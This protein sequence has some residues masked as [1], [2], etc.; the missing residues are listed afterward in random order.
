M[1]SS[2]RPIRNKL[3]SCPDLTPSE[4]THLLRER[5]LPRFH[6]QAG[7]WRLASRPEQLAAL[8]PVRKL[9]RSAFRPIT[10]LSSRGYCNEDIAAVLGLPT[11]EEFLD[12]ERCRAI[13]EFAREGC[14]FVWATC[15]EDKVWLDSCLQSLDK[16][17]RCSGELSITGLSYQDSTLR[18]FL[19]EHSALVKSACQ[20]F[21][22]HCVK[23][24]QSRGTTL[25]ASPLPVREHAVVVSD[26][27]ADCTLEELVTRFHCRS[28]HA[29][30]DT[31]HKLAVHVS[32]KHRQFSDHVRVATGTV[33]EICR[34]QYWSLYRP[35]QHFKK[36]PRCLAAYAIRATTR[37]LRRRAPGDPLP[38]FVVPLPGLRRSCPI[39]ARA[40]RMLGICRAQYACLPAQKNIAT[41]S[42][43]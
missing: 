1:W 22:R 15:A 18:S 23:A 16:V 21:L 34:K 11:A 12:V 32:R 42:Y 9:Y 29:S 28:C 40:P 17:L 33:C 26:S 31:P 39:R 3:L 2:F 38:I 14:D 24:R 5:V 36:S 10:G 25:L 19:L 37:Q 8:E 27:G 30:F 13:Q 6:H 20:A 41:A 7:I 43:T 4:K 35:Q